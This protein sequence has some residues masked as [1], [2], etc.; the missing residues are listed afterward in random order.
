MEQVF[1]ILSIHLPKLL[2][3]PMFFV[4]S[5][6]VD[7]NF[8]SDRTSTYVLQHPLGTSNFTCIGVS[9]RNTAWA[10]SSMA[11]EHF[12]LGVANM[13]L[14][15]M[16]CMHKFWSYPLVWWICSCSNAY[17]ARLISCC[18]SMHQ[19]WSW[20]HSSPLLYFS[21]PSTPCNACVRQSQLRHMYASG[22]PIY[23]TCPSFASIEN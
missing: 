14:M 19:I 13:L 22:W 12:Q 4:F 9:A 8:R 6:L 1:K 11:E 15:A 3:Q 23:N 18:S 10:E 20:I 5:S 16:T 7:A 21:Y 17:L 2:A